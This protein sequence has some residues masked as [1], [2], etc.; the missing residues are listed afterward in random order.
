MLKVLISLTSAIIIFGTTTSISYAA[1]SQSGHFIAEMDRDRN[2]AVSRAE[3]L[4]YVARTSKRLDAI[5]SFHRLDRNHN[6][7]LDPR[8]LRSWPRR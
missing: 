3:F 8:E 7:R 5:G 1:G 4:S 2:G 6:G